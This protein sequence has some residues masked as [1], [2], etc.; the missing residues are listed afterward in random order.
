MSQS[1]RT[2]KEGDIARR[3]IR[4]TASGQIVYPRIIVK[5][6]RP[7]DVHPLTRQD[8]RSLFKRIPLK[9]L[10]G[11][12]RI[13][14]RSRGNDE[15]GHPYGSYRPG[16][17][18]IVLYSLPYEWRFPG[19]NAGNVYSSFRR[20][21]AEITED[22]DSVIVRWPDPKKLSYWFYSDVFAHELGHHFR[23]QY[24][25]KN[26]RFGRLRDEELVAEL[27]AERLTKA[28]FVFK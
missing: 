4:L 28:R 19:Y 10:Y 16:E 6:P 8:L 21:C 9:Y 23:W 7:G 26:G 2:Q 24:R 25:H 12:R 27:H 15:I 1:E 22:D 18:V 11:L 17:K 14:L 3:R 5:P 13:E 20:F